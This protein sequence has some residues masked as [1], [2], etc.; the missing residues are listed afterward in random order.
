M[1]DLMLARRGVI[2]TL[3]LVLVAA[4]TVVDARAQDFTTL[5]YATP[6][7]L[8]A[9]P[10][11]GGVCGSR[12]MTF[13]VTG[14]DVV[15]RLQVTFTA[16]FS[17]LGG[18]SA[19]LTSPTGRSF[20]L[21]TFL[22]VLTYRNP[23]DGTYVF[24]DYGVGSWLAYAPS[25]PTQPV[26]GSFY[27]TLNGTAIT[28]LDTAFAGDRGIGRWTLTFTNCSSTAPG[29]VT[30]AWLFVG[31]TTGAATPAV[32]TSLG[33]IPDGPSAAAQTPGA[34]RDVTFVVPPGRS[35]VTRVGVRLNLTHTW[36]G[37][38]V[39]RLIAPTGE[40]HVLFGFTG[41]TSSIAKGSRADLNGAYMF[42]DDPALPSWWTAVQ[43][44]GTGVV[45]DGSYR[46]SQLG[47]PGATGASTAMNPVFAGLPSA[48]T[49][50]LRLTDGGAGDIGSVVG[51]TLT[52]ETAPVPSATADAFSTG[53]LQ[54]LSVEAPGVMVNDDANGVS[55]VSVERVAPPAHGTLVLQPT[56]AFTY[57]PHPGFAGIDTFQYRLF[58]GFGPSPAVTV[59]L[60]VRPP[61][62]LQSPFELV[63]SEIVGQQVTLRWKAAPGPAPS[64]F[65]LEGGVTPGQ[66]LAVIGVGGPLPILSFQAPRGVFFV[67]VRS[68][69]AGAAS[70]PSNEIRIVVEVPEAP[71]APA[72]LAGAVNGDV[73]GLSWRNT[74]AGGAP[75]DLQ[76]LVTGSATA[77]LPMPL[78]ESLSL[79]GVPPGTYTFRTRA[80]NGAG[81]GAESN[82]V[83]L[84]FPGGCSGPPPVPQNLLV[85]AVG[86]VV[87]AYWNPPANG[88]AVTNYVLNVTGAFNGTIPTAARTLRVPA[89]PGTYGIAVAAQNACGVS[90]FT[91]SQ[92]AFAR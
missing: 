27:R 28:S 86:N 58:G 83:T 59:S 13:D 60:T 19:T 61:T 67:R 75:A 49:W 34:P 35:T 72:Q 57:V 52:L 1:P 92:T 50:T 33:S 88:P 17:G 84:T 69:A 44:A 6:G 10:P 4:S 64:D 9:I 90:A 65:V 66:S 82:A 42:R 2:A 23:V 46:T 62:N 11:Y 78:G 14:V 36:A 30:R 74:F 18:H 41:A 26:P 40:S 20:P 54:T 76:L 25:D 21:F 79:G 32:G 7:S 81:F 71:S 68:V 8:G 29:Q 89:P 56:G 24:D 22:G 51:A 80:R 85:F 63:A 45:P 47:G 55:S 38:L 73:L 3:G 91:P 53:Y 39:A 37:D 5:A 70:A 87:H 15:Q 43:A 48:G 16:A 31:G 77:V 12:A